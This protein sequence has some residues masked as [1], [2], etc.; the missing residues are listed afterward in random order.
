MANLPLSSQSG[1]SLYGE[2]QVEQV[3]TCLGGSLYGERQV[4]HFWT[5][6][7]GT[8]LINDIKGNGHMGI[9]L[10]HDQNDRHTPL[11]TL[12]S[13]NFVGKQ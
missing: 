3:W 5:Y 8:G 11:K 12:P 7:K 10:P 9:P 6:L 13:R 2:V 4:E 1:G